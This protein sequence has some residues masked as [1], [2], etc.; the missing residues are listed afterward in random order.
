MADPVTMS[1]AVAA[2]MPEMIGM[3]AALAAAPE[4]AAGLGIGE[5]ALG[6]GGAGAIAGGAIEPISPL[7]LEAGGG[8]TADVISPVANEMYGGNVFQGAGKDK[9]AAM[10]DK[11]GPKLAGQMGQQMM[12]GD[13]QQPMPQGGGPRMGG[14]QQQA[15][16]VAVDY[17][18]AMQRKPVGGAALLGINDDELKR[19]LMQL[20]GY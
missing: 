4:V 15:Q 8:A 3:E 5:A 7:A 9:F 1:A 12:G 16:P 10:L 19:L 14:Q 20:R 11:Y 2:F 6:A 18:G 17:G 13:E